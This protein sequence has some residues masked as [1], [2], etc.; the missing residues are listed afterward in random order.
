MLY[1][2]LYI[3]GFTPSPVFSILMQGDNSSLEFGDYDSSNLRSPSEIAFIP[4]AERSTAWKINID[5]F[6]VGT[7]LF[8]GEGFEDDDVKTTGYSLNYM[9]MAVLH[10]GSNEMQIP[11]EL[12]E[13]IM[14]MVLKGKRYFI[15]NGDRYW[16]PCDRSKYESLYLLVGDTYFEM[17]PSS[18]VT[19]LQKEGKCLLVFE[20]SQD[21]EWHLGTPF[22]RNY[23]SVWDNK[24]GQVGLG[25]HSTS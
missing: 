23:Y 3:D 14:R 20:E 22:L 21:K 12:F 25:P 9:S 11:K 4:L 6:R 19:S 5:G 15:E 1:E 13:V 2:Q 24:N 7:S 17:P 8:K 16:G 10:S 18:Y